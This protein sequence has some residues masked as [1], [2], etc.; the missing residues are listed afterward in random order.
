MIRYIAIFC[1]FLSAIFCFAMDFDKICTYGLF[2]KN[3]LT[4][5]YQMDGTINEDVFV[6]TVISV[7]SIIFSLVIAFISNKVLY[8]I[9]V[10][11]FL[12]LELFLLNTML[13]IFNFQEV[14]TSSIT[15]CNNYMMLFWLILQMFFLILSSIYIFRKQI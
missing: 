10:G 12:M 3:E 1:L 11:L 14:I 4:I 8:G 2:E 6:F 15:M 5:I 13:T 7:I 9:I